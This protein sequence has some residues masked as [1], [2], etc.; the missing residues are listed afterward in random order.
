MP[1]KA[2]NIIKLYRELMTGITLEDIKLPVITDSNYREFCQYAN[3]VY[4]S[5]FFELIKKQ[6]LLEQVSKTAID[7]KSY[8]ELQF[9]RAVVNGLALVDEVFKKYS[10]EFEEKFM[11]KEGGN[12]DPRKSF[13]SV[14]N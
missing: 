4:T 7:S 5:P 9:G 8:D 6:I 10:N 2:D 12:F 11:G 13:E 3:Q 1:K 14:N